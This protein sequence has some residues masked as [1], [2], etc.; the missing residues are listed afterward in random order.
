MEQL[1]TAGETPAYLRRHAEALLA[2]LLPYHE[3]RRTTNIA[4]IAGQTRLGGEL[5]NLRAALGWAESTLGDRALACAL[6]GSSGAVWLAHN[7]SNEGI[8]RALRL[9]PL[10]DGLTPA[11]EARFNL[12]LASLGRGGAR[13]EC[14]LAS[15][16]AADLY[17][18]LRDRPRLID[19]LICAAMIGWRVGQAQQVAAAI[20]EAEA[21]VDSGAPPAQAAALA[22][23]KAVN[24]AYLAQHEQ[25]VESALRQSAF[26]RDSGN[27]WGAQLA[28]SNVA[29]F[30]CGLGRFDSAIAELRTALDA[31]RRISAPYGVGK[32]LQFLA[33]AHALRGDRDEALAN[34]RAAV[35]YAQRGHSVAWMLLSIALVHARNGAHGRAAGLVAYFDGES[36]REGYILLPMLARVRDEILA[37]TRAA[38][39]P[40]EFDR[41]T[42]TGA[43]LTEERALA[44][45]FD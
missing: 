44:L 2:F 45:A 31:L 35:P 6:I 37:R 43:T 39:G 1:A 16:R 32:A 33:L 24:H 34:G 42:A 5:D 15:L 11:I 29:F 3:Q 4:N 30:G 18:S 12:L 36:A 38:L 19:A 25:A 40:V 26:H 9:L 23:A 8:E 17:R 14:F 10:P 27:E 20:A 22:L 7:L 28:M 21:L 13:R 41:Q